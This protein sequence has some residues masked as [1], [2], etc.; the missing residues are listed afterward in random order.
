MFNGRMTQT[1][2]DGIKRIINYRDA[3][4][5]GVT[6]DQLAYI[7]ATI[8]HETARKC[9]PITE[10]GSQAY[11]RSKKY[12]PWVGRG[13]I[14]CTWEKN[15]KRY[16]CAKPEDAL[17][18]PMALLMAFDGMV[19]GRFTGKKLSQYISGGTCDFVGARRIINGTDRASLIAGY[20]KTFQS[21]LRHWVPAPVTRKA[22]VKKN[23]SIFDTIGGVFDNIFGAEERP[24]D[25]TAPM[26]RPQPNVLTGTGGYTVSAIVA[27]L[28]ALQLL[29]WDLIVSD[30]S[31]GFNLIAAAVIG[32]LARALLP[33]W[34][35][36]AIPYAQ[37]RF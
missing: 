30:P 31:V 37:R 8:Y 20:A 15:Y 27:V 17:Q 13:L 6:N 1:Q 14:Q 35:Q 25:A 36:W 22:E 29:D 19:Q 4:Y 18:W 9:V 21:A 2:V 28:G 26:P 32:A 10:M 23:G 12:Y 5:S 24:V 7:L 33:S 16:N 11:L 34:L 3:S